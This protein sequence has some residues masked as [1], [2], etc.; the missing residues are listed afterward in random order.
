VLLM[1]G[2]P[3]RHFPAASRGHHLGGPQASAV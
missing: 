1:T 3:C 2:F